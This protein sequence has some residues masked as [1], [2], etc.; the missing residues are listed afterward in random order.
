MDLD[1]L[2]LLDAERRDKTRKEELGSGAVDLEITQAPEIESDA[3]HAL[4]VV[5]D[6][7]VT[8]CGPVRQHP[9]RSAGQDEFRGT[10]LEAMLQCGTHRRHG[11]ALGIARCK[12][13]FQIDGLS[14][15]GF[16]SRGRPEGQGHGRRTEDL[17]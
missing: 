14:G 4:A 17:D 1:P 16:R 9:E 2:A 12:K 8:L 3:L 11:I 13:I 7:L 10:D 15:S 6:V 5:A